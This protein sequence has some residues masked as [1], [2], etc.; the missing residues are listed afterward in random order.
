MCC[1]EVY[2]TVCVLPQYKALVLAVLCLPCSVPLITAASSGPGVIGCIRP[3]PNNPL[4]SVSTNGA[5]P[6]VINQCGLWLP[7]VTRPWPAHAPLAAPPWLRDNVSSQPHHYHYLHQPQ[8]LIPS[9]KAIIKPC[10]F[11]P[12]RILLKLPVL[13]SL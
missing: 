3:G 6:R 7:G 10:V 8:P 4:A 12:S 5:R 13:H 1:C 11:H 9:N 2:F